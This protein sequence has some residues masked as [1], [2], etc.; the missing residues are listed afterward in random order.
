VINSLKKIE[1]HYVTV[2]EFVD[3]VG[4][5]ITFGRGEIVEVS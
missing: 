1:E 3:T 5:G 4:D 2:S